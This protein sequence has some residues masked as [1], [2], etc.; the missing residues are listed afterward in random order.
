MLRRTGL[1]AALRI[2]VPPG[3][4]S[5]MLTTIERIAITL[6]WALT[7]TSTLAIAIAASLS[8]SVVLAIIATELTGFVITLLATRRRRHKK[9]LDP[10]A[11]SERRPRNFLAPLRSLACQIEMPGRNAIRR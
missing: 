3:D 7:V 9:E 5:R 10:P 8:A 6:T 4:A 11:A 2:A 1:G